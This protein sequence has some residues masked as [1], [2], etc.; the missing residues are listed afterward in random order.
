MPVK[1][2]KKKDVKPVEQESKNLEI[3]ELTIRIE[4]AE[5]KVEECYIKMNGAL[6]QLTALTSLLPKIDKCCK[7]L[8]I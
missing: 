5:K 7:R 6:A 3:H 1:K 2:E 4:N 8:G